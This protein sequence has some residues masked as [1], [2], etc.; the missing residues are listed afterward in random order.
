MSSSVRGRCELRGV[1]RGDELEEVL[2]GRSCSPV[3][4]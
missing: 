4:A 1:A 3:A 2:N